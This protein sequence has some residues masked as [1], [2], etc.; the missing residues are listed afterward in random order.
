MLKLSPSGLILA[1][2]RMSWALLF[3]MGSSVESFDASSLA[4]NGPSVLGLKQALLGLERAHRVQIGP[5]QTK[6][7]GL[8]GI[9]PV[10]PAMGL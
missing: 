9:D 7:N 3:A 8:S 1:S 6:K 2:S 4:W 10:M 5:L